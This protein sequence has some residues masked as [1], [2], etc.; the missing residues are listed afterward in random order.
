VR[1][2]NSFEEKHDAVLSEAE[3][4]ALKALKE[5]A[6]GGDSSTAEKNVVRIE[7]AKLI[8]SIRSDD[9]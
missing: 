1:R 5:I 8:L 9:A 2:S 7:A 6:K 3:D 4:A